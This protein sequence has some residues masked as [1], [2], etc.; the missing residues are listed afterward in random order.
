M[1]RRASKPEENTAQ[2]EGNRGPV[3]LTINLQYIKDLS[4]EVP[5]GHAVFTSLEAAP[6]ITVNIDVQASRIE[7]DQPHFEVVLSVKAEAIETNEKD[8]K[9][10][11]VVF[12]AELSYAAV[13]TLE[14]TPDDVVEPMLLIETPRLLFPFARSILCDVTRDGGF[15]PVILQPIDFVALWHSKRAQEAAAANGTVGEA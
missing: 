13:V 9:K 7:K 14:N 2:A 1:P 5:H 10:A 15:P 12:V 3:P 6:Q 11:R 4:F 8:S